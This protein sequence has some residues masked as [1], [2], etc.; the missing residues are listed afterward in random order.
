MLLFCYDMAR[1]VNF[2]L[3]HPALLV[4]ATVL[5]ICCYCGLRMLVARWDAFVHRLVRL[6]LR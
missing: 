1:A 4:C 6:L 2:Y 5:L 3:A